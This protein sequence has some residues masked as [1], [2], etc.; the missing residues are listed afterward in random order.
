M[1]YSRCFPINSPQ[2]KAKYPNSTYI[3]RCAMNSV[4][5]F[6]IETFVL[7]SERITHVLSMTMILQVGP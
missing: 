4:I 5:K 3:F 2:F 6:H 7:N 1:S